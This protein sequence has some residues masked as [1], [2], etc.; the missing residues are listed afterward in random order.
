MTYPRLPSGHYRFE[1]KACNEDGVW[2]ETGAA[3]SFVVAP[4]IWERTWFRAS[5]LGVFTVFVIAGVRYVSFRRLRRQLEG[6]Q[7]QAALHR[8]R[9]RIA[10]DIHDDLGANLTQIALLSDFA[11]QDRES[12]A[13]VDGHMGNISAKARQA[14]QSLDEIVWAVNPRND[15]LA[16]RIIHI[17]QFAL[18]YLQ[19]AGV[20]CRLDFPDE[21]P[22]REVSSDAR[23]GLFLVVKEA[24]N[25]VVKHARA[26]EVRLRLALSP[27][28]LRIEI[29]DDGR[30]F[31]GGAGDPWADGLR[32][33]RQRT[34]ELGGECR[35]ASQS[36]AG[37]LRSAWNFPGERATK[38]SSTNVQLRSARVSRHIPSRKYNAQRLRSA[39]RSS[40]TVPARAMCSRNSCAAR[41]G[42]GA[43]APTRTA[44]K[45]CATSPPRIR[46]S[47]GTST[48]RA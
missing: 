29:E 19:V 5:A 24:L 10:K 9:A 15:T 45:P 6:A 48:C 20:R 47:R 3:L 14:V 44:R 34:Q 13:T 16:Q 46:R 31:E 12:P 33:M 17:G 37:V 21:L 7:Q 25:N 43:S 18:D 4:F 39:S 40:R 26:D 36:G 28:G 23:H 30:G 32:N 22:D 41:P 2:N 35:I 38:R 42:S 27:E 11:R 8:E 1:V